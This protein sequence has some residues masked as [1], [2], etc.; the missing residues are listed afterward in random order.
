MEFDQNM[1]FVKTFGSEGN[2]NG[3]LQYPYGIAVDAYD[4]IVVVDY[5]NHRI[6]IFSKDVNWKKKQLENK[7]LVK[8]NFMIHVLLYAKKVAEYLLVILA[9]IV[10]K[11]SAQIANSCSN[12]V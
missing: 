10:F 1:Q 11:F 7:Y 2:G 4:N 5:G 12:M 6:H 9:T 3:Q 8:L